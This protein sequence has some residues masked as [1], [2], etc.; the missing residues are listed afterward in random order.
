MPSTLDRP[1]APSDE[2]PLPPSPK[3]FVLIATPSSR[4]KVQRGRLNR[5]QQHLWLGGLTNQARTTSSTTPR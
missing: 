5:Y 4:S 2:A 1:P 3:D